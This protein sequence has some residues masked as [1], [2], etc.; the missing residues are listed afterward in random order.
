MLIAL[1]LPA[2]Q[3]AREAARR[4]QCSNNMKQVALA[5]Q[6]YH[7]TYNTFP[8]A[9]QLPCRAVWRDGDR[10]PRFS[11]LT[12]FLPFLE[13]N[14][15]YNEWA[16]AT[17]KLAPWDG[18]AQ[19]NKVPAYACP[20]DTGGKEIGRNDSLRTSVLLSLG[21]STHM[22]NAGGNRRGIFWLNGG[23]GGIDV[24]TNDD[25]LIAS[26]MEIIRGQARSMGTIQDGTSN[27]I[28]C[29]ELAN[30]K[31]DP[32]SRDPKGAVYCDW[33]VRIG[34]GEVDPDT[35][36]PASNRMNVNYC[37]NTAYD[38]GNRGLLK[39]GTGAIWRGGRPYDRHHT[40]LYFNT[41]MPPNGPACADG[42]GEEATG[43]YP[44]QSFHTAGVNCGF[45]DGSVRFVSDTVS[46]NGLNGSK[47]GGDPNWTGP[48]R[49][50][51]WGALGS[52]SGG[53]SASL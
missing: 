11:P 38:D 51:V 28:L 43:I 37:L 34:D 6:N 30:T 52:I 36:H 45:V 14:A 13:Q 2:V 9:A 1:L 41:L 44:P 7:D 47:G 26:G 33:A 48:S 16:S 15:M 27:T 25:A 49:F 39:S 40:Y 53:E 18:P 5:A 35:N 20:S 17:T 21:D 24:D 42:E 3:A 32:T 50:G 22:T 46:T 19:T 12:A 23:D 4:M 10:G 8:A 29:S 31:N